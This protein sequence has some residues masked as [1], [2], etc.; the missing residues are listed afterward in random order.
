MNLDKP[1]TVLD[2]N[3]IPVK[4]ITAKGAISLLFSEKALVIDPTFSTYSI[5]EWIKYSKETVTNLPVIKSVSF[6][7]II[8]EVIVLPTYLRKPEHIRRL[9]YSRSSIF[10]RDGYMCLYCGKILS[11]AELT[12]DHIL[13]KSK[14]G[15][16][17]WLNL[18]S[19]CK[20]CNTLKANRT[21]A[22]AGLKLLKQPRIPTWSD[23]VSLP[24]SFRKHLESSFT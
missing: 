16:S 18:V 4:I 12:L 3:Y 2:K 17:S 7:F 10:K 6:D 9:R 13:P 11:R 20:T 5:W 14:G 15:V 19:C 22:E 8:P 24:A 23:S 21:P 1:V